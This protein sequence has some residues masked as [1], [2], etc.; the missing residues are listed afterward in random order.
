VLRY[1]DTDEFAVTAEQ[2]WR[3]Y[4]GC[5]VEQFRESIGD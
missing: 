5:Q 1:S 2:L 4:G 3:E